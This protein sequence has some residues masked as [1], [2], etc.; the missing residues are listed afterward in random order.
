MPNFL[1]IERIYL[2]LAPEGLSSSKLVPKWGEQL[3]VIIEQNTCQMFIF[4]LKKALYSVVVKTILDQTKEAKIFVCGLC[5]NW[6]KFLAMFIGK[7]DK[8]THLSEM[9]RSSLR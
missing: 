6:A 1:Y 2:T 5:T 4:S 3:Q 8:W 9:L 7:H